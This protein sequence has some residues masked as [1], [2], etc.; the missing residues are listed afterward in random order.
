MAHKH[1]PNI[2]PKLYEE[3]FLPH[4]KSVTDFLNKNKIDRIM[5]DSD[6]NVKPILDLVV[7]AGITGLWPL[8][9]G[10][11]M[12]AKEIRKRNGRRLFLIGNLDKREIAKGGG[13]EERS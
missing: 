3:F 11:G 8:E 4:Y 1:G 9:V 12:D 10:A 6:G 13:Y 5:M 7:K 2:S